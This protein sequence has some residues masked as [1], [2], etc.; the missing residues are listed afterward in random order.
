MADSSK[1]CTHRDIKD[2]YP[3]I[4]EYDTKNPIYGWKSEES[5]YVVYNCGLVTMLYV[6]GKDLGSGKQTI[7]TTSIGQ[8]NGVINSSVTTFTLDDNTSMVNNS[9]TKIDSEIVKVT[10]VDGGGFDITVERAKFGTTAVAHN[11]DTVLYQ[12]FNP[13]SNSDW[14]YDD[15][16]DFVLLKYGSD[17]NDNLTEA[18]EDFNTLVDR[19]IKNASRYFDSRVDAN[20]P[21]DQWKDKSGNFDYLVVRTTAL[22]SASFLL[23][24]V[25]PNNPVRD[26]FWKEV[27]FNIKQLN[28]GKSKLSN[29]ASADSPLG[30]LRD[31]SVDTA[32]TIRPVDTRGTFSGVYD[33]LKIKI[34]DVSTNG[35]NIGKALFTIWGRDG[36]GILKSRKIVSDEKITGSYQSIGN[37]L[38]IR[39]S[40]TEIDGTK[41]IATLNDEWELECWGTSE[42]VLENSAS[43]YGYTVMTRR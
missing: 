8:L 43:S 9:Y 22:I 33:L 3:N 27:N 32:S 24:S 5:L 38:Q 16:N 18:G 39:F 36:S 30:V 31:I 10:A 29:Q 20:L 40:A 14:I 1:Y 34:T 25:D 23:G 42:M 26:E 12:H 21:R 6:D 17:P 11:D 37:G 4:D 35:A 15:N 28:E 19:I 13:V 41:D 2:I 7:G